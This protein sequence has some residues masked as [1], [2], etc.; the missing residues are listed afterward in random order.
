MFFINSGLIQNSNF[1]SN[2]VSKLFK[3]PPFKLS[4]STFKGYIIQWVNNIF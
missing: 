2:L 1:S 4:V 3:E